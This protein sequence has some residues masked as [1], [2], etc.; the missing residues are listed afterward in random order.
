MLGF[1]ERALGKSFLPSS[2]MLLSVRFKYVILHL[3]CFSASVSCVTPLSVMLLERFSY[4][5]EKRVR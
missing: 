3:L 5:L 4:D 1:N 2:V